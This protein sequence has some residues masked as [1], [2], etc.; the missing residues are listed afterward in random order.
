MRAVVHLVITEGLALMSTSIP[1]SVCVAMGIIDKDANIVSTSVFVILF[2]LVLY[3][4]K[5]IF[6]SLFCST[7][8]WVACSSSPCKNGGTCVDVN[9]DTFICMCRDRFFGTNCGQSMFGFAI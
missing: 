5:F 9:V 2:T 7:G 1:S 6:I 3:S 4:S 8:P